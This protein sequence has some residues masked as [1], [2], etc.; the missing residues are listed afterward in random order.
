MTLQA[1]ARSG[2]DGE[3]LALEGSIAVVCCEGASSLALY[4]IANGDYLG[5]VPVGAHPVHA[6]VTDERV[7]VATMGERSIDVVDT[8]GTVRRIDTGVLGPSHFA[9]ANGSLFI[10]CTASDV[11]AVIDPGGLEFEERIAVGAEPH[12]IAVHDGLAYVGSRADGV[13][14]VVDTTTREMLDRVDIGP[15]ALVQ[16][17]DVHPESGLGFAVDQRGARVVAFELGSNPDPVDEA[18]VGA[19]PPDIDIRSDR[20]FVPGRDHGTVHEFGLDL[21]SLVVHDGF[22]TPVEV[23]AHREYEWVIDR[24]A[25]RIRSLDGDAVTTHAP[26]IGG[27]A[28]DA[29]I[30][31]SHYD[32]AAVSLVDPPNGIHWQ[33]NALDH[34]FGAVIV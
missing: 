16:G 28:T 17:V 7:F 12:D 20:L 24:E 11:V 23:V 26:A 2:R 4:N 18:A 19:D 27:I 9:I 25:A 1:D 6:T 8:D 3:P 31:L 13:V 14:S 34:P 22:E 21:E 15:N 10:P 5:D 33:S 30:L 32:D 29:G